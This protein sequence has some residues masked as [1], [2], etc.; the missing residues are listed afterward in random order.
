MF[1]YLAASAVALSLVAA[2]AA[3]QESSLL[4]SHFKTFCADGEGAAPRA[5]QMGRSAGWAEIPSSVLTSDPE[6]PF[7]DVTA[8]MNAEDNGDL[9]ILMIGTMQENYEGTPMTMKVCA[10]M[11]GNFETNQPVKPDPR[12]IVRQWLGME[13]H[14]ALM[15]QGMTGYAFRMVDGGR[16]IVRPSEAALM[17][18]ALN[19]DLHIVLTNDENTFEGASMLMYMRPSF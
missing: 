11:G 7:E 17:Q 6:N 8:L 4:F 1:R 5:L 2:P 12:P 15:E 14:P 13:A 19:G 18:S 3:A 16:V 9:S 10:V